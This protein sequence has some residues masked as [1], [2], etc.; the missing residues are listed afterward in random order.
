MDSDISDELSL[1]ALEEYETMMEDE[2]DD[3]CVYALERAE[4][5][6]A[7]QQQ[8]L[9]RG[10]EITNPHVRGSFH[11][12]V[13]TVEQKTT[14][15]MGVKQR[16][17]RTQFRQTDNFIDQSHLITEIQNG[18]R[19]PLQQIL[20]QEDIGDDDRLFFELSSNRIH[21]KFGSWQLRGRDWGGG[22]TINVLNRIC[23]VS[24]TR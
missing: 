2:G 24:P 15:K 14:I 3:A 9:Q 23:N 16:Q 13:Q 20:Q 19:E 12:D 18:L 22:A 8:L 4:R 11:F 1:Q 5:E 17:I 10:G 7:F 21:D 6:R